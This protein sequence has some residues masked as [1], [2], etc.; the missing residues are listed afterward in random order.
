MNKTIWHRVS[1]TPILGFVVSLFGLGL[2]LALIAAQLVI[3]LALVL[4]VLTVPSAF[5]RWLPIAT[6]ELGAYLI[7]VA[8]ALRI[9][10]SKTRKA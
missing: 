1:D 7:V 3:T 8:V 10:H 9:Y 5:D 4:R 2:S 6:Q